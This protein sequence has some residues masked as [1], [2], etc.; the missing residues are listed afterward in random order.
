MKIV[1]FAN[2]VMD[3]CDFSREIAQ[4]ADYVIG[5]DGGA[6]HLAKLDIK[7]DCL[8]GDFDSI[9]PNLLEDFSKAGVEIVRF[10]IQKDA[11]DLE[12]A[13]DHAI[14]MHPT[15]LVILCGFGERLDHF[16]GNIHAL[17]AA[18]N[19]NIN[20]AL[21]SQSTLIRL[22]SCNC[23]FPRQ[24]YSWISLIPLTTAVTGVTTSGLKYALHNETLQIGSSRG[25][26]NEFSAE[27]VTVSVT[28]GLL[29]AICTK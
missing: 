24:Q 22:I 6:S 16:L 3:D 7:P 27:V 20:A 21:I 23:T 8:I 13:V 18:A 25:I 2:G 10:P 28:D 19:A 1:I 12:L 4:N 29:L 14:Q 9:C 15:E 17:V 26:S 11:T 5:A